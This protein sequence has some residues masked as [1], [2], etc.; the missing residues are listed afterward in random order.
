[1]A[2]STLSSVIGNPFREGSCFGFLSLVLAGSAAIAETSIPI[3]KTQEKERIAARN[4]FGVEEI[5]GILNENG[6]AGR[7]CDFMVPSCRLDCWAS[8]QPLLE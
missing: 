5:L 4:D 8:Y 3:E 7:S 6:G 2:S 1:M